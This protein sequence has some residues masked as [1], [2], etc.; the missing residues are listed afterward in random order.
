[1]RHRMTQM[2]VPHT[3]E[4]PLFF[5][6]V[7]GKEGA[8]LTD[9]QTAAF[10]HT[11]DQMSEVGFEMLIYSFGSAFNLETTNQTYIA[12][13]RD[14]VEYAKSKGIEVGGY[15]LICLDRGHKG[16]GGNVGDEFSRVDPATGNLSVDACFASD[17]YDLLSQFVFDFINQTGISMLEADG[18]FGGLAC[19]STNHS[20]HDGLEDSVYQ[21]TQLQNALF[22]RLREMGVYINQPDNYF[23]HG[24]SRSGMGYDEEQYSLPRWRQLTISRMGLYDDL[25]RR[26]PT[27]GWMFVPLSEYHSGGDVATFANHP[28][29]LDFAIAQY[30]GAGTGACYRGAHL[31]NESTTEGE[32][33]KQIWKRRIDF[34]KVHRETIIQPVVHLRRPTMYNWDGY[35]H[36]HPLGKR[37]VGLA[38]IF[39]PTDRL[40]ENEEVAIP[41][42]YTSLTTDV[43][44]T[45]NGGTP[46]TTTLGRDYAVHLILDLP[47][48]S[49]HSI[50]FERV[51]SRSEVPSAKSR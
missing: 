32:T 29:E 46:F 6:A 20:H 15:D 30:L 13:I 21:Q 40:L 50:V 39:N 48:K 41:L 26:L 11:I 51:A 49:I 12:Q 25:Y 19:S 4:N 18:P 5:H 45:V 36:V 44:V 23:Y 22:L 47:P 33:I 10:R 9:K 31:Y 38:M 3:T 7:F 14:Q 2:L 17:W 37:E 27:Q 34:Y 1:M 24:G 16:Y 42:Y 28:Q 35:L 8:M 43:V